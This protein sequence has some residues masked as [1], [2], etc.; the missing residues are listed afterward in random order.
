MLNSL[1]IGLSQQMALRNQMDGI[2]NNVAN[3]NTTGFKREEVLFR[4]FLIPAEDGT[5]YSYVMDF[6]IS[7]DLADGEMTATGNSFDFA[8]KGEGF[9]AVETINGNR[10][11]RNGHF[12]LN[13]E[14]TLVTAAGDPLL[15]ESGRQ[16]TFTPEDG[17]ITIAPD[18]RVSAEFANLGALRLSLVTFDNLKALKKIGNGLYETAQTPNDTEGS[19][20]HQGML[21]NSNVRS[22]V[23]MTRMIEV[24]R[25]YELVQRL[26]DAGY[27]LERTAIQRLGQV[28]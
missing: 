5:N 3:M 20:I 24:S 6:G 22:V 2:A 14:G 9:F 1:Y 12:S 27:D 18:G 23:E 19:T 17:A 21:E 7:R 11:T 25:K 4:E 26:I 28:Q 16:L 10:Y 8:I 13:D 15:D